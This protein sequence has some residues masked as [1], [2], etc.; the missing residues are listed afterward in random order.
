MN[1]K[2]NRICFEMDAI[3]E[4]E[5]LARVCVAAYCTR[6]DPTLEEVNDI[7]TAVSEAVTNSIIHG[8]KNQGGPISVECD[9]DD[10]V[11][12]IIISDSG[13]GIPDVHKAMEPLFTTGATQ[14]RS[15]MGFT[16]MEIFMD[17]LLVESEVGKGTRVI[18]KKEVGKNKNS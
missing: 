16:F 12:T 3:S 9:I 18:M 4:N 8:Y 13:C 10:N 7:K 5:A 11:L 1:S 14:E 6:L 2:N 17:Q 15:G